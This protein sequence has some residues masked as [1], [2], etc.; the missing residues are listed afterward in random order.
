MLPLALIVLRFQV[1]VFRCQ[2]RRWW[3]ASSLIEIETLKKRI[4]N[5]E[6][7]TRNI[8]VRYSIIIIFKKRLSDLSGRSRRRSLKRFQ[9]S[10]FDI[11]C[12]IFCGSLLKF[13][14]VS[15]ERRRWPRA[16]SQ[17]E[18]E[19]LIWC[20]RRV[21]HRA[22]QFRRARWPALRSQTFEVSY[23]VSDG[24]LPAQPLTLTA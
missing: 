14:V 21:G 3:R 13:C 23:E 18:I 2:R 10:S 19:T 24:K 22:D 12:S 6:Q 20:C 15:Y 1:S 16:S 17:I 9:T 5:I 11:S 8:E 7:G 4:T